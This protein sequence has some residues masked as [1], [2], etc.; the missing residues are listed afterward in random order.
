MSK[1]MIVPVIIVV[2]FVAFGVAAGVI[3]SKKSKAPSSQDT[4]K[5]ETN[6]APVDKVDA[7]NTDENSADGSQDSNGTVAGA[8]TEYNENQANS[9]YDG[10][11]VQN[12]GEVIRTIEDG[13]GI[14]PGVSLGSNGNSNADTN[15]NNSDN[16]DYDG[17]VPNTTVQSG[18]S[19]TVETTV[20][21][22]D[23]DD[24]SGFAQ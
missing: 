8:E 18:T 20:T 6:A 9:D 13:T 22:V 7:D 16:A 11:G 17:I 23:N 21:V 5:Q 12:S 3:V 10:F 1:S 2:T 19:S 14:V 15:A 4:E 24:Y